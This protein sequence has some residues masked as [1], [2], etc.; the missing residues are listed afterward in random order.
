MPSVNYLDLILG[1][2]LTKAS[3]SFKLL[4]NHIKENKLEIPQLSY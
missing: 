4:I 2:E 3:L 1:K